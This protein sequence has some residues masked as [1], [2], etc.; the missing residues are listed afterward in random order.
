MK[1]ILLTVGATVVLAACAETPA[2]PLAEERTLDLPTAAA[3]ASQDDPGL[4]ETEQALLDE[5]MAGA[6]MGA[7]L[8][9]DVGCGMLTGFNNDGQFVAFGGLF[10]TEGPNG[11]CPMGNFERTNPDGTVD[12]HMKG[13]GNFFLVVFT[14]S[15]FFPSEGS[16]VNWRIVAH[17]GGARTF[18]VS[19]TLS[20]GSRVRAHF[21]TTPDG[22]N[23]QGNTLWIE[24][25]GYVVGGPARR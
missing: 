8:N 7:M 6:D 4:S 13:T 2:D 16:S 23:P 17:E 15:G 11:I 12:L 24:S 21:T 25:L 22:K 10:P 5:L 9:R 3:K 18:N 20:D 19:G 14:P 1:K